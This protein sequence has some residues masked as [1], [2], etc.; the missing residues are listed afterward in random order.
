MKAWQL[1]DAFGLDNLKLIMQPVPTPSAREVLVRLHAVSLNSRD[2]RMIQGVYNPKQSL[3]LIPVS[4]G[5]GNVVACGQDVRQVQIGD[6]VA[7][8]MVQGWK[9]GPPTLDHIRHR[10]LGGPLP[11]MLQEFVVLHEDDVIQIPTYLS[12]EE[13]ATLPCAALTAW[14]ALATLGHLQAKQT[15][16]VQGTGGVSVLALQIARA[17]GARVFATSSSDEKR[18]RLEALG[19]EQTVNYKHTPQWGK[20]ARTMADE[21]GVEHVIDVG[22]ENTLSE[23]LQAVRPGAQI[24]VIGVLSGTSC[25]V[26]LLAILMR[27]IRLQGVF[28]GHKDGFT[29]MNDFLNEHQLRPVVD[30]TFA[31]GEVPEAFHYFQSGSRVGKVC[32]RVDV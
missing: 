31:F 19:A 26:N 15:V 12:D 24:S 8:V 14:S 21:L 28:V 29:A 3:P 1:Q 11:G 27:Q 6:R 22:G 32:V 2:L 20:W 4:D 25:P 10:T 16:L 17:S 30:R 7:A 5:V 9:T 13:A 18:Q 23:S